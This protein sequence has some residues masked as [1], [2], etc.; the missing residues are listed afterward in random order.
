M[1]DTQIPNNPT[2]SR[3]SKHFRLPKIQWTPLKVLVL[4]VVVVFAG[5]LVSS[6]FEEKERLR[7]APSQVEYQNEFDKKEALRASLLT[8]GPQKSQQLWISSNLT[9]YAFDFEVQIGGR[10]TWDATPNGKVFKPSVTLKIKIEKGNIVEIKQYTNYEKA[11]L[12][13]TSNTK[14]IIGE[15][16]TTNNKS[17]YFTTID[18]IFDII[19]ESLIQKEDAGIRSLLRIYYTSIDRYDNLLYLQK[20]FYSES[21]SPQ[22]LIPRISGS[23]QVLPGTTIFSNDIFYVLKVCYSKALSYKDLTPYFKGSDQ[24]LLVQAIFNKDYGYPEF[25]CL[26]Y[27]LGFGYLNYP[28]NLRN[29]LTRYCDY[30][31]SYKISNLIP[32]ED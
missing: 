8:E 30:V 23:G 22:D 14:Y 7:E 25:V 31:I 15:Y 6:Y 17:P 29:V 12:I 20:L 18:R 26:Y 16:I 21:V 2:D 3:Q 19:S 27:A 24:P 9:S 10:A 32:L 5:L 28:D 13:S 11:F 1:T 4:V